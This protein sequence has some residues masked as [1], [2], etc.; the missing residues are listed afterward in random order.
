MRHLL[1]VILATDS[2]PLDPYRVNATLAN[3]PEFHRAFQCKLGD[4]IIR[5]VSEQCTLW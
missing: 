5:P 3:V 1:A 2:H 4:P